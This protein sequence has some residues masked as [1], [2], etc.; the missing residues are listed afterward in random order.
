MNIMNARA[1]T[2]GTAGWSYQDWLGNFYPADTR[3]TDFLSCYAQ[4]FPG[5]EIDSTYYGIP[6]VR[7]VARWAE[8]T[9]AEFLFSPKMVDQVTHERF[10]VDCGDLVRQYVDAMQPLGHKLGQVVLQFPY[11]KKADG[12]TLDEFL[13][14]LLPFL[15]SLPEWPRFAVEVRNK[16]FLKTPLLQALRQRSV[17]MVLIDHI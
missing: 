8:A 3:E 7:T 13:K 17:P 14:R 6:S 1:F 11:Y 4:H 12:V 10:L 15:D 2:Y 5:V 16:T 9:P